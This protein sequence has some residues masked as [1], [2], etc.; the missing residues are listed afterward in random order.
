[1]LVVRA[2]LVRGVCRACCVSVLVVFR[3][4]AWCSCFG[5]RFA[6]DGW[7]GVAF[8]WWRWLCSAAFGLMLR[9]ESVLGLGRAVGLACIGVV[10]ISG[11]CTNGN[12]G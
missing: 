10:A 6:F 11:A 5:F 9:G 7:A 2:A 8:I 3:W 4:L 1:M 12:G